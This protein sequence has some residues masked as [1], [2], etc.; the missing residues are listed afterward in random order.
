MVTASNEPRVSGR[1][2]A[3]AS[4]IL[5]T[6]CCT[7]FILVGW[8]SP[9]MVELLHEFNYDRTWHASLLSVFHLIWTAPCGIVL[10]FLLLWKD[11]HLTQETAKRLNVLSLITIVAFGSFWLYA[12]FSRFNV[13]MQGSLSGGSR[14]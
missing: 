11:S 6:L 1:G 5:A 2:L 14:P 13:L 9:T 4:A 12:A 10:G 7:L 8:M 3:I